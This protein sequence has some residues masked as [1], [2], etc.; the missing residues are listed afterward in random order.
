M[1]HADFVCSN[2]FHGVAFSIIFR[3]IFVCCAAQVGGRANTNGRV[4]NLLEQTNLQ[5]RYITSIEQMGQKVNPD[6]KYDESAI[7]SYRSRSLQWL[8]N[9]IEK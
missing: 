7:E 4:L 5:D 2:S 9:A 8:N 1:H 6:I 3:R